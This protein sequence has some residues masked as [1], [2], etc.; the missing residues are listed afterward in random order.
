MI[1]PNCSKEINKSETIC[2]YCR[3]DIR[4]EVAQDW[5]AA[6]DQVVLGYE[7]HKGLVHGLQKDAIQNGWGHRLHPKGKGWAFEF[8]LIKG[9]DNKYL[10]TMTDTGGHGLTGKN[11]VVE[12]IPDKLP[13]WERLARFEH[14]YFSGESSQA[15]GLFGRGKLLFT[16]ASKD[17]HVIFDS[18]THDGIYRLNERKLQG[19]NLTN[20]SK[21]YEG[22][23]AIKTLFELTGDCIKPLSKSG[24]RIMIVNP[25]DEIINDI[26]NGTFLKYI[27]E[28]WWQILLKY[29]KNGAKITVNTEEGTQIAKVP[30]EFK[31][32]PE[33]ISEKWKS[34]TYPLELDYNGYKL[35]IKKVRFIVSPEPVPLEIKGVYLYRREMKVADLELRNIP[36][37]IA[38]RFYGYVELETESEFERI[39]L[40][41]KIEDVEHYSINR[42]KGLIR[43]LRSE[44]Q[45]HFDRFKIE[46]GFGFHSARIA[47]EKTRRAMDRA[48]AELNKRMGELGISV[49]KTAIT[50][51]ITI[52]L[53]NIIFPQEGTFVNIGDCIKQIKFK[54]KNKSDREYKVHIL[55][56]TKKM[57]GN[58]I[59][60]LFDQ[61]VT[62]NKHEHKII[63]PFSLK[64]SVGRYPREGKINISCI[65]KDSL[66]NKILAKKSIPIFIG[67]APPPPEE[68]IVEL[69]LSRASFPRGMGNKRVNYGETINNIAYAV[70]NNIPEKITIKFK[71]RVLNSRVRYEEIEKLHEEDLS[72]PP[73]GEQEIQCPNIE[74]SKEKYSVLDRGKGPAILRCTI[75]ASAPSNKLEAEIH[76]FELKSGKKA[77]PTERKNIVDSLHLFDKG[78]KLAKSDLKFW[79]EMDSGKGVFE[80]YI[81]WHGGPTKPRSR[82]Q[83]EGEGFVC[84]L[85]TK[86][87]AYE[88]VSESGDDD[89]I[90]SYTYEQLL[91]QT[92]IL[93]IR[94]DILE[95]WPELEGEKYKDDM[96]DKDAEAY[97][98]VE[99]C[100]GTLDYLYADYLK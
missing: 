65:V 69:L 15:A 26:R 81:D 29:G 72:L 60:T 21:A 92:L 55:T 14:M 68:P 4:Q 12:E 33:G 97:E 89:A 18:L 39:Y 52:S 98:K 22:E 45:L 64:I 91:R 36:E 6:I 73:F 16:A 10:L 27:E 86:H 76:S 50:K 85:N 83:P 20:F 94:K 5:K 67:I 47:R 51:D 8:N 77:T 88:I 49:G 100:L 90:Q 96:E 63:G 61:S 58:I 31:D 30:M 74:V 54:I 32:I 56:F 71:A 35:K 23:N 43:K 59:D 79:V 66:S 70:I 7:K 38:D 99:A 46:L 57:Y 48:L 1:C 84:L 2:P 93:L 62:L 24:T 44:V 40:D 95:Y 37:Q 41:E 75:T 87:P 25:N 11:M 53:E 3:R 42:Q 28:T 82:I 80:D 9:F 13:E 34:R 19:K 78:D 17:A